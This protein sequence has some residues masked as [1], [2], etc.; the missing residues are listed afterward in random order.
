M[1][2]EKVDK[3]FAVRGLREEKE[4]RREMGNLAKQTRLK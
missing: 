4:K 2:V 3:C 1:R